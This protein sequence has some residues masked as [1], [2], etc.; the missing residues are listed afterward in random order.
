MR[1]AVETVDA[2]RAC[3]GTRFRAQGRLPGVGLDCVGVVAWAAGVSAPADY[4]LRG[5]G[6]ERAERGLAEL[7]FT[8]VADARPGDVLVAEPGAGLRHLA[9]VSA[10][11]LVVH[12]HAGLRRVVEGPV[13][14]A[15]RVLSIWRL[16][17]E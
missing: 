8:P 3:V 15:W 14:P 11:G 13:D 9:V 12:A 17:G 2:A 4:D 16:A 10:P 6:A 7:G 1:S 5:G